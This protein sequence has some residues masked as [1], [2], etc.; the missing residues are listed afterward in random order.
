MAKRNRE[1]G[2]MEAEVQETVATEEVVPEKENKIR[3]IE[4]YT[5]AELL[6]FIEKRR[7]EKSDAVAIKNVDVPMHKLINASVAP[8]KLDKAVTVLNNRLKRLEHNK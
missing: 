1:E 4:D 2:A 6:A 3:P 7:K 8:V 5:D